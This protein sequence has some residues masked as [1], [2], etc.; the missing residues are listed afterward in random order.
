MQAWHAIACQACAKRCWSGGSDRQPRAGDL[1]VEAADPT[2]T[3]FLV[4]LVVL[5]VEIY[6]LVVDL[7][8]EIVVFI[9]VLIFIVFVFFVEII[10][11]VVVIIVVEIVFVVEIEVVIILV[12]E[13]IIERFVLEIVI[14]APR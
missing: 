8:V 11:L 12:V 6:E 5:V 9:L 2:G 3:I 14:S 1:L 7:L 13:V 4:G 10:I